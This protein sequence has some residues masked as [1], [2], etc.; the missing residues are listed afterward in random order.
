MPVIED[1]DDEVE[2]P[3]PAAPRELKPRKPKAKGSHQERWA[4]MSLLDWEDLATMVKPH[5][6]G[7]FNGTP[8]DLAEVDGLGIANLSRATLAHWNYAQSTIALV[9]C[10]QCTKGAKPCLVHTSPTSCFLCLKAKAKCLLVPEK[11][12]GKSKGKGKGKATEE[13]KVA[14]LKGKK[15]K[16]TKGVQEVPENGQGQILGFSECLPSLTELYML[17]SASASAVMAWMVE[18]DGEETEDEA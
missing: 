14:K 11:P 2:V 3:A 13:P 18:S 9:P 6:T 8:L 1:L 4:A 10:D 15:P 17:M 7:E 12:K 5:V 16:K